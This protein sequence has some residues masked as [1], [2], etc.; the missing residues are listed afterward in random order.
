[1][2]GPAISR[3]AL[4][5]RFH[6]SLEWSIREE[7]ERIRIG[8]AKQSLAETNLPVWKIAENTGFSGEDYL[9]K[10]LRRVT[11]TTLSQYRRG[12]RLT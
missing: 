9:G 8:F 2:L 6:R 3:R 10:V 12:H 7:I 5:I 1:M 4:E 11:N